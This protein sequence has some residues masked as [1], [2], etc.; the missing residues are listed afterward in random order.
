M[1]DKDV[2]EIHPCGSRA[3]RAER[4][5]MLLVVIVGAVVIALDLFVWRP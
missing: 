3:R 1:T 4:A 5:A 2:L